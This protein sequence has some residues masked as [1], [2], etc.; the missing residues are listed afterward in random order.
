MNCHYK[1]KMRECWQKPLIADDGATPGGVQFM[2]TRYKPPPTPP[3]IFGQ[4]PFV[5]GE[6]QC[7]CLKPFTARILK[8]LQPILVRPENVPSIIFG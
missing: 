7:V 3:P 4:K 6:G 5:S 1:D 2:E 8:H